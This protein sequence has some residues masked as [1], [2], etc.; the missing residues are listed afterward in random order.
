M[1]PGDV[2]FPFPCIKLLAPSLRP[3]YIASSAPGPNAPLYDSCG[4]STQPEASALAS[5]KAWT[6]SG[7]PASKLVLGLPAYGYVQRTGAQRLR[8]RQYDYGDR[9]RGSYRHFSNHY[10][11]G[12]SG[13]DRDDDDSEPYHHH[14][15]DDDDGDDEDDEDRAKPKPQR[16][17]PPTDSRPL[18]IVDDED[19]I[20]FRDL[21]KQGALRAV[22]TTGNDTFVRFEAAGGFERRWDF[23][24]E[25]P[26]LRS[27][28]VGQIVTYDDPESLVLKARFAKEAGML[29]VNMFDIHGDT[30]GYDLA[31][32][33][34]SALGLS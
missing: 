31:T 30:D 33:I 13:Y 2:S 11:H 10:G 25:T 1:I 16:P 23:C 15:D 29:G 14:D 27:Q 19:Q 32:S 9:E 21:V 12:H 7:F 26:F 24:S 6:N 34:R 5:Y 18:E 17:E 4:N 3:F 20:Q 28:S 8:N 22:P